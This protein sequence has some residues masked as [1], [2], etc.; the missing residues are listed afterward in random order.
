MSKIYKELIQ[1][2]SNPPPNN[3]VKQ[4]AEEPNRHFFQRRHTNGQQVH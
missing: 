4:W 2:T 1:L 3:P